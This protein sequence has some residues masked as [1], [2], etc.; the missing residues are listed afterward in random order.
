MLTQLMSG[1]SVAVDDYLRREVKPHDYS[2]PPMLMA[3]PQPLG[4]GH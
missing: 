2:P 3:T 1:Q 4:T